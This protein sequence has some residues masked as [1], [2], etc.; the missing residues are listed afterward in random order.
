MTCGCG[1][2]GCW[3]LD[4]ESL[5]NVVIPILGAITPSARS[6]KHLAN[7][8]FRN[9]A[10]TSKTHFEYICPSSCQTFPAIAN[11]WNR[12]LNPLR[13]LCQHLNVRCGLPA[14]AATLIFILATRTLAHQTRRFK[15]DAYRS[16]QTTPAYRVETLWIERTQSKVNI[17][18]S[19]HP[20][21]ELWGDTAAGGYRSRRL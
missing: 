7:A 21:L 20:H 5:E 16:M 10:G 15:S 2:R 1:Q 6:H 8:V 17:F 4:P 3:S 12:I 19:S 9:R 13:K 18:A 14:A 11:V